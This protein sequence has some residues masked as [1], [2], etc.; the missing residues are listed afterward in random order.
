MN[1]CYGSTPDR[2]RRRVWGA[3]EQ[4]TAMANDV[5]M[6]SSGKR[7][8]AGGKRRQPAKP[9]EIHDR[10]REREEKI[11]RGVGIFLDSD[12]IVLRRRITPST[13]HAVNYQFGD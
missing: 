9:M 6:R 4:A 5:E 11:E 2:A 10:C 7:Y 12:L 8:T 13:T 3:R 1:S